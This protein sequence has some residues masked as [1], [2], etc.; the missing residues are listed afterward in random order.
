MGHVETINEIFYYKFDFY[1]MQH[2]QFQKT[3]RHRT[4]DESV[5]F[6]IVD[7][8]QLALDVIY[9]NGFFLEIKVQTLYFL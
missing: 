3:G 2:E 5:F 1:K 7:T 8:L 4:H 6:R 9:T